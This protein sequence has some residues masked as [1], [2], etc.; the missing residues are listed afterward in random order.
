MN[1]ILLKQEAIADLECFT[2]RLKRK[3]IT[4]ATPGEKQPLINRSPADSI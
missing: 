4:F 3:A 1:N 2:P